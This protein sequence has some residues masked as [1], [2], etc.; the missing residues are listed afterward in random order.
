MKNASKEKLPSGLKVEGKSNR[1]K[2]IKQKIE[3]IKPVE[4]R[5]FSVKAQ[6]LPLLKLVCDW[7]LLPFCV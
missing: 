1:I 5:V 2:G 7:H 6:I 3:E 4:V